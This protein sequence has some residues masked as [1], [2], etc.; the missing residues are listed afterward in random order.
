MSAADMVTHER[1]PA[2]VYEGLKDGSL[3]Y[4]L[5]IAIQTPTLFPQTHF[6]LN[7]R[8]EIYVRKNRAV[9]LPQQK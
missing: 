9:F 7:P 1:C 6:P 8:L 4:E 3:G 5:A 2:W